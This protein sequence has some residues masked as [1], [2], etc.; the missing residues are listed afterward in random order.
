MLFF[1]A[2][3]S[4]RV[5]P[6]REDFYHGWTQMDTDGKA[7][8]IRVYQRESVVQFLWLRLA[9]L[10]SLQCYFRELRIFGKIFLAL[11]FLRLLL[12]GSFGCGFAAL[13]SFAAIH[14]R[15][16]LA[17][18]GILS[19]FAANQWKFLTMNHLRAKWSFPGQAQSRLIKANQVIFLSLTMNSHPNGRGKVVRE[20]RLVNW[21]A[22][23][24][25]RD[26]F[27]ADNFV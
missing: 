23:T 26:D 19:L 3:Q 21:T 8:L 6:F 7:L 25:G 18:L 9:A 27:V 22:G 4:V 15:L 12:L 24:A 20:S 16:R 10:R 13:R 5:A 2:L 11:R 14:L 1:F 17:A